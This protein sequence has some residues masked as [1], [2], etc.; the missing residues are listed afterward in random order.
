[1]KFEYYEERIEGNDFICVVSA[2]RRGVLLYEDERKFV[3]KFVCQPNGNCDDRMDNEVF[4]AA[5]AVNH[6]LDYP[7]ERLTDDP[8]FKTGPK[9][10]REFDKF[11]AMGFK[12]FDGSVRKKSDD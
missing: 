8:A 11:R 5:M 7:W 4:I 1:M 2:E 10:K 3:R 9:A 12:Y 6:D